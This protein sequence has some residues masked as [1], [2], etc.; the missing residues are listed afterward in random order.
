VI[1]RPFGVVFD[2]VADQTNAPT[3]QLDLAEVQ[4]ITPGPIGVGTEHLF[5][6]R[7]AGRRIAS[8]NRFTSFEPGRF[9]EFEIP[10]GWLTGHASYRV[11]ARQAGTCELTSGIALE[12][13]GPLP[14]T[15]A[16]PGEGV[17]ARYPT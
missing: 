1:D 7:F 5:I 15:G 13:K 10:D 9:V 11:V 3:W 4:R 8:R 12:A 6:R 16:I 2:F 14:G 17:G